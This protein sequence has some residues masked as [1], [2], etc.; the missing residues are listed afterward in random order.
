M[1]VAKINVCTLILIF[2]SVFQLTN[3]QIC[4]QNKESL[5]FESIDESRS[6][7]RRVG[8]EC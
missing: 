7:E 4:W 8:K 6:E 5:L 3:A 1:N 2:I